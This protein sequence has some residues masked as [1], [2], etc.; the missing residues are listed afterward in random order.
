MGALSVG[1]GVE[2]GFAAPSGWAIV[3]GWLAGELRGRCGNE[4]IRNLIDV[5]IVL[6]EVDAVRTSV[7]DVHKE[8]IWQLPLNIEIELLHISWLRVG[9]RSQGR[10][11]T[12]SGNKSRSVR[13]R[14]PARRRQNSRRAK[15]AGVAQVKLANVWPAKVQLLPSR[16][17]E[18]VKPWFVVA[19]KGV[20]A[21]LITSLSGLRP[22]EM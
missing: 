3:T 16:V 21:R 11:R 10:R 9:I 7:G 14:K 22:K 2:R 13:L 19:T 8:T 6:L 18:G 12:V 17:A 1:F 15:G 5:G 4:R 20:V